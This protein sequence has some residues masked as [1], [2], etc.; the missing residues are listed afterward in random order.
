MHSPSVCWHMLFLPVW[1][2]SLLLH[3]V[4]LRKISS[5]LHAEPGRLAA[6]SAAVVSNS[7]TMSYSVSLYALLS[8]G[9]GRYLNFYARASFACLLSTFMIKRSAWSLLCL[10]SA[11]V[12]W[13]PIWPRVPLFFVAFEYCGLA[14][15]DFFCFYMCKR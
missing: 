11:L 7:S 8:G 14:L 5:S 13:S 9:L 10:H 2:A 15:D 3:E 4:K 12:Q 1:C 6:A